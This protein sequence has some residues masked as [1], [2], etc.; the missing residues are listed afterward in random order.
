ML[1]TEWLKW[2]WPWPDSRTHK[3]N[4]ITLSSCRTMVK[5]FSASVISWCAVE[6]GEFMSRWKWGQGERLSSVSSTPCSFRLLFDCIARAGLITQNMVER[7]VKQA[8]KP[9]TAA[10]FVRVFCFYEL[11]FK[12][13]NFPLILRPCPSVVLFGHFSKRSSTNQLWPLK[14]CLS[15]SEREKLKRFHVICVVH[16]V[17]NNR[18]DPL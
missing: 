12:A 13:L 3:N 8:S 15:G 17:L 9:A 11:G 18:V 2:S 10:L 6:A 14:L 5:V 1:S 16:T 7:T 4:N